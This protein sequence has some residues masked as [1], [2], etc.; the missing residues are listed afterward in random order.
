MKIFLLSLLYVYFFR[1]GTTS[2]RRICLSNF[3]VKDILKNPYFRRSICLGSGQHRTT[4]RVSKLNMHW[5][6]AKDAWGALP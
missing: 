5:I 1:A 6:A 4:D 3:C 2:S